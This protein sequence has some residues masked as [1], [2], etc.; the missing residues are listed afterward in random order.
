MI[1]GLRAKRAS[2]PSRASQASLNIRS[3]EHNVGY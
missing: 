2:L 1:A 3:E